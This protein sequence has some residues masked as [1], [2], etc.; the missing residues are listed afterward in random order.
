VYEFFACSFKATNAVD[1]IQ[2][3]VL[4]TGE[5][6][7]PNT[8]VGRRRKSDELIFVGH[9]QRLSRGHTNFQGKHI[10]LLLYLGGMRII[11]KCN[12]GSLSSTPADERVSAIT[13]PLPELDPVT[14][15]NDSQA[16]SS[17]FSPDELRLL[18][19]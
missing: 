13:R 1:R 12:I 11:P 7:Q 10:A 5:Q 15:Q 17:L 14:R 16:A 8:G 2:E 19:A 3:V 4:E 6:K 9:T 18:V